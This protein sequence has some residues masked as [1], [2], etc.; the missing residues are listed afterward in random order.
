MMR[1]ITSQLLMA[2]LLLCPYLCMGK[3]ASHGG[4]SID[5]GVCCCAVPRDLGRSC[6]ASDKGPASDEDPSL[7][8][9]S[10]ADCLCQGAISDVSRT[11]Q[12][13]IRLPLSGSVCSFEAT[14]STLV[15]PSL[16]APS[17]ESS[18]QPV[19]FVTG[20]NVCALSGVLLL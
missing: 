2:V 10:Q 13:E 8:V 14:G 6:P 12:V 16:T 11:V 17:F 5:A 9:E 4:S 7:P 18:Q 3:L 15:N 20:R 19:P 1:I